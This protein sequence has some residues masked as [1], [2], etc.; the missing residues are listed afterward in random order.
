MLKDHDEVEVTVTAVPPWGL[1]V[2]TRDGRPGF[3]DRLKIAQAA[4][5]GPG[6]V[7]QVVILDVGRV[8]FRASLQPRDFAVAREARNRGR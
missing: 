5:P 7:L 1:D 3:I 4:V 2:V 8:P 6:D